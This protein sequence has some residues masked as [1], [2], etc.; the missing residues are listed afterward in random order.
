VLLYEPPIEAKE[1]H[2]GS[3]AKLLKDEEL[4]DEDGAPPSRLDAIIV[5]TAR[6][7]RALRHAMR[8][9]KA[10]DCPVIALCSRDASAEQARDL[11]DDEGARALAVNVAPSTASLLPSF[12]TDRLLRMTG[13]GSGSDLSLKRNLGLVLARGSNWRRVL[14][15]DD[16]IHVNEPK[17]LHRAAGLVDRY[18]AVGLANHGFKDN[19]VVCH[20]YRELGGK[21][22]TFIG[23][24]AMIVDALRTRSFYP[25]VYNEDWLFL[26]GDGVPFRAAR[27]GSMRQRAFDPFGNPERAAA[28]EFGDTLA[29]GLFWLLDAGERIDTARNGFWGDFVFQ[30]RTFIELLIAKLGD[31][32]EH[33]RMRLSLKAARGR[34][35]DVTHWLCQT[36][37]ELWKTDLDEW[38]RF[39]E[40]WV[41]VH[42]D[43]SP[44]KIL[45]G[46]GVAGCVLASKAY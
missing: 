33:E 24:G 1:L 40:D 43:G 46:F 45:H 31:K 18:R 22:E 44:E 21:Q 4:S 5:P 41:P 2:H 32:P 7:V 20:A 35:A 14:F 26:I 27:A 30:R 29:E 12:A 36:F 13:F 16:D 3:H 9:G 23:G 25:N 37:L 6:P 11:A 8:L 19:S 10:I 42:R 17:T 39:L 38:C 34:S 28:E 15:L